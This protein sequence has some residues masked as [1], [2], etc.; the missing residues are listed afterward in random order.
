MKGDEYDKEEYMLEIRKKCK[1]ISRNKLNWTK[2]RRKQPLK[3]S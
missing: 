1:K 2:E 3:P